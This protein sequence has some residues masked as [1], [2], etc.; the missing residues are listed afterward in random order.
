ME[1]KITDGLWVADMS[2]TPYRPTYDAVLTVNEEPGRVDDAIKHRHIVMADSNDPQEEA[3]TAAAEW[4]LEQWLD[5]KRLLVRCDD[6]GNRATYVVAAIFAA[7]GADNEEALESVNRRVVF[8]LQ[9]DSF[10]D[11][12]LRW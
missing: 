3:L 11:A 1:T 10:I 2:F 6:G 12:V 4:G 5:G 7:M 9:N 8:P